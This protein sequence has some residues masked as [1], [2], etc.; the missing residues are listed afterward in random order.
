MNSL[1]GRLPQSACPP[2]GLAWRITHLS[3]AVLVFTTLGA[4]AL[5][6]GS[7]PASADRSA[8]KSSE[9]PSAEILPAAAKQN[10]VLENYG[11][12]PL[13]FEP[14]AGQTDTSVK[15]LSRG[16]G[17]TVFLTN[18]EAVLALSGSSKR[19]QGST[20]EDA[21]TLA[22]FREISS[23]RPEPGRTTAVLRMRLIDA[24]KN[25]QVAG[26]DQLPGT[27]NY[28]LGKD[29]RNWRTNVVNYRKVSYR[30]VYPG[31]DLVY[32]GNQRQLEYDFVVAPGSDPGAIKVSFAGAPKVRL[33]GQTG[34]LVLSTGKSD[35]RFHKPVAYQIGGGTVLN[36]GR[37]ETLRRIELRARCEKP[38]QLPAWIV[39]PQPCVG[40][41]SHAGLFNVPWRHR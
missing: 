7:E 24:N 17:Y 29:P 10:T 40:D 12:I 28:F 8:A 21:L 11:Q 13:S 27:S 38:R 6:G 39:R 18:D 34:D 9:A 26:T 23:P 4:L 25:A 35:V 20:A 22:G 33:D 16:P 14:N 15:F 30:D 41:R 5:R 19:K 32:Y 2:S 36:C 37:P 31:I 1:S 3:I